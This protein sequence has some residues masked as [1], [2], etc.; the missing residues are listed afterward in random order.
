ML[1]GRL[2][3]TPAAAGAAILLEVVSIGCAGGRALQPLPAHNRGRGAQRAERHGLPQRRHRGGCAHCG[4]TGLLCAG[5]Q[6]RE[7]RAARL[8]PQR[9]AVGAQRK[10]GG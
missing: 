7:R 5:A 10:V 1:Y 2:G 3:V 8:Q 9:R 6:L 4:V